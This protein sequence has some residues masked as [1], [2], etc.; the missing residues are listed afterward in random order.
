MDAGKP[1]FYYPDHHTRGFSSVAHQKVR[2]FLYQLDRLHRSAKE[3]QEYIN[4]SCQF[5]LDLLP[6]SEFEY[7]RLGT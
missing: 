4:C 5:A 1:L 6:A 2:K 7:R 3:I